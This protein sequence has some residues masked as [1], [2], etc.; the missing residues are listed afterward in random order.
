MVIL[1]LAVLLVTAGTQ[2]ASADPARITP[3]LRQRIGALQSEKAARTPAQRKISSRLLF[4]SRM[5]R[6]LAPAPGVPALRTSVEVAP[7]G[8]VLIDLRTEVTP[9][10][11]RQIE[12]LGGAVESSYPRYRAVRARVPLDQLEALAGL[13]EVSQIRPADRAI[14]HKLDAT[15]G[16]LAHRA[17]QV[18]GSFGVDGTGVS[19]GV[20][21]DGVDSLASLQASGD[22]PPTVTVLPGQ[23]GSGSEGTAM[24]E[25]IHDLAP[26][27]DLLFATAFRGQASFAGNIEKLRDAGADIIVD[28]VGYFAE[29]VF[30]DDDVASAVNAVT[31][32]GALYFSS[33]GNEGNLND[34]TSGVWEGDFNYTGTAIN[35]HPAHDFGGGAW[36]N[37]ITGGTPYVF[38]LHWSDPKGG[39]GNDYDLYLVDSD[40]TTILAASTDRQ[41]GSADPFEIIGSLGSAD[42]GNRLIVVKYSGD[43]R[44]LHLNTNRGR[45]ELATKGQTNG[46]SAAR[47][48]FSVAAVDVADA[49]GPGGVF[50]G[51]E[52]VEWYSSDG[53]RRVFYEA[54]GT[55]I[56]PG[57]FSATGGE[58]RQKPDLAAAD[59]VST[60]TPGFGTFCGTSAAAPHAAAIAALL[61]DLDAGITPQTIRNALTTTALDIEAPGPDRDSGAGIV[62]A[63]ASAAALGATACSDGADDDGDGLTDLADPGCADAGDDSEK[64][65]GLPCDDGFDNDGDGR[66]DFDPITFASPGD[67]YTLPSGSGD[68]GCENPSSITESPQCQDG[69]NNDLDQDPDPGHIDYDAGY[70]A[71]GSPHPNGPDPQCV[72]K[73]W[74]N[75]EKKYSSSYPCGLGV[76]LALLLPPLLWLRRRPRAGRTG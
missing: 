37:E 47:D 3:L 5:R 8:T 24:L 1:T 12:E 49:G 36:T 27:A 21:S 57:D 11:L 10:V 13:A 58:L 29:A 39:S 6:G 15:E 31:A 22:L 73:P 34:G 62:E 42:V 17:D 26:G 44:F 46:H 50:D 9:R 76:E 14:T 67:Q 18:R 25:I 4:A 40:V 28:D 43:D 63:F 38:T 68:P 48:A 20:L 64:D 16:D 69:I 72:G 23:K 55:P 35:G 19:I 53:P 61:L 2:S 41:D 74:R 32:D 59:C 60:A 52:P 75:Q 30:Q 54:D 45:L 56:T 7:D 51:T 66:I 70:S 65:A 71:V 33:A